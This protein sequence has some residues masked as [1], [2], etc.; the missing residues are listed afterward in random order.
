MKLARD[1]WLIFQRQTTLLLRNPIGPLIGIIQPIFYLLLFAPMQQKA[2]SVGSQAESYRFFVPAL[3]VLLVL[4]AGLYTGMSLLEDM[5]DGVLD[6]SRVTPV[7]RLALLLGR[8][9]RD[10]LSISFQAVILIVVAVPFG[11]RVPWG[12][13]SLAFLLLGV[14]V[15]ALS[16]FSYM[17]ALKLRTA[18][19]MSPVIGLLSQQLLLLSGVLL[20]LAFAPS[21]LRSI[22][23]VN[24]FAHVVSATQALFEGHYGANSVWQTMLGIGTLAVLSVAWASRSFARGL[25]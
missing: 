20:P 24:P 8:S 9:L 17:L 4:F 1:T 16:A 19:S 6:R 15:I 13:L 25:H 11:L 3:L 7:S 2:L 5:R 22:A 10:V 23:S 18:E 14:T 21:W 12:G